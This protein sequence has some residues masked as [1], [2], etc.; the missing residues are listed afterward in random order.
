[1]HGIVR[2]APAW[3]LANFHGLKF[4]LKMRLRVQ[5]SISREFTS[6]RGDKVKGEHVCCELA[7]TNIRYILSDG[8]KISGL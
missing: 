8:I 3:T 4:K 2:D 1:M 6:S 7:S 5:S